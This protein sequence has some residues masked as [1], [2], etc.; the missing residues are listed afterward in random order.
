MLRKG[1]GFAGVARRA[2]GLDRHVGILRQPRSS[3]RFAKAASSSAPAPAQVIDDQLS[4]GWR[5]ATCP[6][7]GRK[8]GGSSATGRPACS[9]AGQS[10]SMVPSVGQCADAAD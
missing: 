8:V 6:T 7:T 2:G 10:Q 4:P 3:D 5:S 1:I 9:A